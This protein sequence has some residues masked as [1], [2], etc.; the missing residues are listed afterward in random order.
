MIGSV[1]FTAVSAIDRFG[2]GA[3]VRVLGKR[4]FTMICV[5]LRADGWKGREPDIGS[6][7]LKGRFGSNAVTR[8]R[9]QNMAGST[10]V[11]ASQ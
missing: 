8:I 5:A 1:F 11:S 2:S 4:T 3:L 6:T 9:F 10:P 7:N